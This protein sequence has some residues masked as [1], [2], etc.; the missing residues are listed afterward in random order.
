M[1]WYSNTTQSGLQI[2]FKDDRLSVHN[3]KLEYD[4]YNEYIRD[5]AIVGFLNNDNPHLMASSW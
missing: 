1:L 5:Y 3:T 4:V 2:R